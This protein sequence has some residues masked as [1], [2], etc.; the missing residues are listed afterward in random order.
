MYASLIHAAT[1]TTTA[2]GGNFSATGTWIG[3]VVPTSSD[4]I[5]ISSTAT[6]TMNVNFTTNAASVITVN[7]K[8][9]FAKNTTIAL[10]VNG[11]IIFNNGG[12]TNSITSQ[13]E[14]QHVQFI[15]L[16]GW[17]NL[18][19]ANVAGVTGANRSIQ[20]AGS[21]FT[22]TLNTAA[23]Y[24]FNG[25]AIQNTLGLPATVNSLT[26]NNAAGV[27]LTAPVTTSTLTIG[28]VTAGSI[29]NDNG[30]QIKCGRRY[31]QSNFRKF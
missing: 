25:T 12:G 21:G 1:I 31:L 23:N 10:T 3:G 18:I 4:N 16:V 28:S 20:L 8:I 30:K 26:I 11:T 27:N 14:R 15:H 24:E 7:G 17:G 19:T 5:I 29:L 9:T 22:V 2:A 6:V 13:T